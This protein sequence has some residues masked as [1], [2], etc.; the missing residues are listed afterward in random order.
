MK[1]AFLITLLVLVSSCATYPDA[2]IGLPDCEVPIP[3]TDQIWGG[4][5]DDMTIEQAKNHLGLMREAMSHNSLVDSMCIE[6]LRGRITL[7]DEKR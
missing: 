7:H 6:K 3:V 2:K 4:N 1:I 5:I